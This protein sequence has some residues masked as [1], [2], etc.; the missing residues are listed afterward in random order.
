MAAQK[1]SI[2][3]SGIGTHQIDLKIVDAAT[4]KRVM[5]CI[6]KNGRISVMIGGGVSTGATNG[7]FGQLID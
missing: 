4:R 6:Q 2:Q 1:P 7:G 3:L 5:E